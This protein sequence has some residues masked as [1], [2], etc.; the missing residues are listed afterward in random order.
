MVQKILADFEKYRLIAV[1]RADDWHLGQKMAM[2]MANAGVKLI[3]ITWN[4]DRPTKLISHLRSS[5]PDCYIGAGTIMNINELHEAIEAGI[6]FAF[7]PHFDLNL[8]EFAQKQGIIWI[9]GTMSPTEIVTAHQAGALAVK[10]FPIQVL[11]GVNYLKAIKAPLNNIAMIPTGGIRLN[12]AS[13]YLEAGALAVGLASDLFPVDLV[14]QQQ[15]GLISQRV[16]VIQTQ[17]TNYERARRDSNP[18]PSD[19]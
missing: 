13:L 10:V 14:K 4:S 3:E 18:R 16:A 6:Q 8:L 12:Q 19:P 17:L 15:W 2:A 1:I 7:S 9:P 5:L 11:G